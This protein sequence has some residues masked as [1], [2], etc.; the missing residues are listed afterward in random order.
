MPPNF[1]MTGSMPQYQM[2]AGQMQPQQQMMQRMHP[3]QQNAASMSPQLQYNNPQGTP[4]SMSTQQF[5]ST[6][7]GGMAQGQTASNGM[8]SLPSATTPQTPTFPPVGHPSQVNGVSIATSPLSPASESREKERFGIIL[9]INQE[10][11]LDSLQMQNTRAELKKELAT[12]W[13]ADK[14]AECEEQDK[15]AQVDYQQ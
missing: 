9:E 10:L 13:S 4:T 5:P 8:Q 1:M 15:L 12:E 3:S 2:S 7:A 14:K 11:L 6:Q